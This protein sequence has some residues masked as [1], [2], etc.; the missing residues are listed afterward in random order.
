MRWMTTLDFIRLNAHL[1][2]LK[3]LMLILVTLWYDNLDAVGLTLQ[4]C[5]FFIFIFLKGFML[6]SAWYLEWKIFFCLLP[7]LLSKLNFGTVLEIPRLLLYSICYFWK[8][9]Y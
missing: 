3:M 6:L 1:L 5:Y 9:V 8:P 2:V 7:S 4:D